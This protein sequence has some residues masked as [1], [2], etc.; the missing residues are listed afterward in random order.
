MVEFT[1][2]DSYYQEPQPAEC[3]LRF[4]LRNLVVVCDA[5]VCFVH[6][7]ADDACNCFHFFVVGRWLDEDGNEWHVRSCGG[8]YEAAYCRNAYVLSDRK[9]IRMSRD[10]AQPHTHL[11][12]NMTWAMGYDATLVAGCLVLVLCNQFWNSFFCGREV[13]CIPIGYASAYPLVVE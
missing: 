6:K 8:R 5:C 10:Q 7:D 12:L 2:I 4:K 1:V 13:S 11:S 3:S 9:T